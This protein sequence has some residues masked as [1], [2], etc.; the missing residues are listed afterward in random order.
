M[1]QIAPYFGILL[2]AGIIYAIFFGSAKATGWSIL[3]KEFK[4]EEKLKPDKRI[5]DCKTPMTMNGT[6][7]KPVMAIPTDTGLYL[8]F[9]FNPK[10]L[11]PWAKFENLQAK[12]TRLL[13]MEITQ[14][15]ATIPTFE[16]PIEIQIPEYVIWFARDYKKLDIPQSEEA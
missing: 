3:A 16:K 7:I 6:R 1:E 4:T 9:A 12:T 2:F 10:L 14:Y 13:G 8:S 15:S 5:G 11:I